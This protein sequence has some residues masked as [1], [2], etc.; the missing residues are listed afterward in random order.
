M[1][2]SKKST[3]QKP[4]KLQDLFENKG[5]IIANNQAIYDLIEYLTGLTTPKILSF[6]YQTE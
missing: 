2:N 6:N 3:V 5:T 1:R 4:L